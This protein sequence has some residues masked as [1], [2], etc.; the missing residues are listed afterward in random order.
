MAYAEFQYFKYLVAEEVAEGTFTEGME[1]DPTLLR[2]HDGKLGFL[3]S[4]MELD[5]TEEN[6]YALVDE[7]RE[8]HRIDSVFEAVFPEQH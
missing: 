4:Q 7:I 6:V 1:I 5:P 3:K 2:Q 8:R